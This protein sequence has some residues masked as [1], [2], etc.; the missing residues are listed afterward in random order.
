MWTSACIHWSSRSGV[1][2]GLGIHENRY[3]HAL[4]QSTQ[5]HLPCVSVPSNH[6][7][8]FVKSCSQY[9]R[10]VSKFHLWTHFG[11]FRFFI[12]LN[13]RLYSLVLYGLTV[14]N[15]YWVCV[16]SHLFT[17]CSID[18]IHFSLTYRTDDNCLVCQQ[19][20]YVTSLALCRDTPVITRVFYVQ[21][22]WLWPARP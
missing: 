20:I 22:I 19:L 5:E 4:C 12:A 2:P 6:D 11:M 13:D 15:Q 9:F 10:I 8:N 16:I 18:G 17:W 1:I 21:T 3:Q 14:S 7:Y